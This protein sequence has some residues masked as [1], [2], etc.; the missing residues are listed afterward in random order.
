MVYLLFF[1]KNY[2]IQTS[3]NEKYGTINS[4]DV[5]HGCTD[6]PSGRPCNKDTNCFE[7]GSS[8]C[9]CDVTQRM[10]FPPKTPYFYAKTKRKDINYDIYIPI[11]PTD[12][13]PMSSIVSTNPFYTYQ[14]ITDTQTNKI[15]YY[16]GG[17]K[18]WYGVIG[19]TTTQD[20]AY[21]TDQNHPGISFGGTLVFH[22][23]DKDKKD[24][25]FSRF[26]INMGTAKDPLLQFNLVKPS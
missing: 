22:Y 20:D 2:C 25:D 12:D 4:P 16:K 14:K 24:V 5:P 9:K 17:M 8:G 6:S 19:I 10:C 11:N 7:D 13:N 18:Y 21:S 3:N 23:F 1:N 15:S 26:T